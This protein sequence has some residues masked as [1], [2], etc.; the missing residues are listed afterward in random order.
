VLGEF[1]LTEQAKTYY[2]PPAF[3]MKRCAGTDFSA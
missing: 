2:Y 1:I 3:E